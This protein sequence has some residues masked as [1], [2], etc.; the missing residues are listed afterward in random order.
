MMPFLFAD[1]A[2]LE[3]RLPLY[4]RCVGS[5]EQREI[6]R[7]GSGYPAHQ[8]FLT[9][10]GKGSFRI[11]D[12]QEYGL[13]A[14]MALLMPAHTRHLYQPDS[15]EDTWNLGYIAFGGSAADGLLSQMGVS[16][17]SAVEKTSQQGEP[18]PVAVH[19]PNFEELWLKL[20]GIWHTIKQGGE[21]AYEAS[22]R[23]YD[24]LL[25]WMEGQYPA[26]KPSKKNMPSDLPNSALQ[27]AVQWIHD[28]STERLLLSN[29]AK[30]AGYS[31]QHF[32]RLFVAGYG[33]TPQQYMLQLRMNRSLQIFKD[34]PGITVDRV[35]EKLGMDVSHFIRVFKRTY[36]TTPKRYALTG[37][38]PKPK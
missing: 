22:R 15:S 19:T 21:H 23:L 17:P 33:M 29:V 18:E 10:R 14:G 8:L 2:N 28:H 3:Q 9:R 7:L 1:N 16:N 36:G 4:V 32:H 6:N 24:L 12:G 5:H 26:A 31:V 27:A 37:K 38:L 25:A 11:A 34:H 20:E 13:S 30:A 35:A